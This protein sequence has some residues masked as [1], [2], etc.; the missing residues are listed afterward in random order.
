MLLLQSGIYF[1]SPIQILTRRTGSN[2]SELLYYKVV[3]RS[4]CKLKLVVKKSCEG[5]ENDQH[6][7]AEANVFRFPF[8]FFNL[9]GFSTLLLTTCLLRTSTMA[10]Q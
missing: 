3:T 2:V 4:E 8:I 5:T 1:R 9:S 6:D 10:L 7:S